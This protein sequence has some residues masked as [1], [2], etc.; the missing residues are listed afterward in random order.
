MSQR[1]T[2]VGLGLGLFL[3]TAVVAL[4][5]QG[6]LGEFTDSLLGS[7]EPEQSYTDQL[8]RPI[9]PQPP[10]APGPDGGPARGAGADVDPVVAYPPSTRPPIG[11]QVVRDLAA[12]LQEREKTLD[13]RE[14]RLEKREADV[15]FAKADLADQRTWLATERSELEEERHALEQQRALFRKEIRLVS[16]KELERGFAETIR[17]ALNMAQNGNPRP[18]RLFVR[19]AWSSPEDRPSIEALGRLLTPRERGQLLTAL[20]SS[21][22][23]DSRVAAEDSLVVEILDAWSRVI[24]VDR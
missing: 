18:V 9:R 10:A 8:E 2:L 7:S 16:T 20:E 24:V 13:A 23:P 11:E 3:V 1:M 5:A 15:E 21:N 6:R 22:Q 4:L 19:E 12:Q 14:A 17:T